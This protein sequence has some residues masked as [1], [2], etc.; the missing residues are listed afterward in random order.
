MT[1]MG[2]LGPIKLIKGLGFE[3]NKI[4]FYLS[5]NVKPFSKHQRHFYDMEGPF[6]G[7]LTPLIL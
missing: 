6:W 1:L 2:P 4:A 3:P 5:T 7:Y